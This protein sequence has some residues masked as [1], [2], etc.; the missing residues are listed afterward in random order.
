MPAMT[1]SFVFVLLFL[2]SSTPLVLMPALLAMQT[3]QDRRVV[4]VVGNLILWGC[5]YSSLVPRG[6]AAGSG[7]I[8]GFLVGFPLTPGILLSLIWWLVLLRFA[9]QPVKSMESAS[10]DQSSD[11][12]G[13]TG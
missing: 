7:L 11:A 6:G 3:R 2:T 5:I 8:M 13:D 1:H 4:I 12:G 10:A 9:I